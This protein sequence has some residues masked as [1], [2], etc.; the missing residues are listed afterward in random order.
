[1]ERAG[2]KV[3]VGSN[4]NV[5]G[6]PK[7]VGHGRDEIH[8]ALWIY[9]RGPWVDSCKVHRLGKEICV[10]FAVSTITLW[11]KIVCLKTS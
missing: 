5:V 8:I 6:A 1:M 10:E 3:D 9:P 7:H 4:T 2:D 11:Q